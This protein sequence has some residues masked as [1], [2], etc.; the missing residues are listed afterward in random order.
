MEN[1]EELRKQNAQVLEQVEGAMD[2]AE[3]NTQHISSMRST[4]QTG[5][6]KILRSVATVAMATGAAGAGDESSGS[7]KR[8]SS[9]DRDRGGL[10]R[11]G[12][13][14][15]QLSKGNFAKQA[16]GGS[17]DEGRSDA[18]SR[19]AGG[20]D[21]ASRQNFGDGRPPSALNNDGRAPSPRNAGPGD[22]RGPP[23]PPGGKPGSARGPP[24]RGPPGG[25]GDRYNDGSDNGSNYRP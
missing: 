13:E 1:Q 9:K 20:G 22:G 7:A 10:S 21:S 3:M 8:A 5:V 2:R 11:I 12:T 18:R 14:G 4:I 25:F 17:D 23:G 6:D 16:S 15:G 24:G 19:F